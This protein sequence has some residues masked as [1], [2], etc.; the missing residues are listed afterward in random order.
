MTGRAVVREGSCP[1]VENGRAN[2]REGKCPAIEGGL[3]LQ[4]FF[5]E[6]SLEG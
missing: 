3:V 2:V 4:G 5:S 1:S 6:F